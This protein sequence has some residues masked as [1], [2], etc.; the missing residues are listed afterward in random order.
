MDLEEDNGH[1]DHH[2]GEINLLKKREEEIKG[3][4]I[5]A[6]LE[7]QVFKTQLDWMEERACK[8]GTQP[9]RGGKGIVIQRRW[10]I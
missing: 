10:K 1:F 6:G 4:V 8:C 5:G 9:L 3:L 2:R 7:A